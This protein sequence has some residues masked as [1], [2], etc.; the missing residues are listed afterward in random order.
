M[1]IVDR[2]QPAEVR[3]RDDIGSNPT[4]NRTMREII[5]ARYSRRDILALMASAGAL[6]AAAGTSE[7]AAAQ[8]SGNVDA[9]LNRGIPAPQIGTLTFPEIPHG[10]DA[11][12][13]LSKG[14]KAQV[15]LRWGDP[16]FPD[17]SPF[18]PDNQSAAVQ[19]MQ[20]GYN[21]DFIGFLPYSFGN[22][23]SLHGLL[24]V[25]HEYA[26]PE[27]MFSSMTNQT[28]FER[29]KAEQAAVEM[30]AVG[31]SIVEIEKDGGQWKVVLDGE[32]NR[33]I[34]AS[35]PIAI[36]GPAAGSPRLVTSADPTGRMVHGTF[37]NCGG[38]I[39]PWGT[40]LT[41]E[42]NF[43]FYFGGNLAASPEAAAYKR[44]GY[45]E[46]PLSAWMRFDARF[47]VAREPNESNRFGW[48]VEI[49]PYDPASTPVK[50]T[51]LGRFKHEAAP[52][53]ISADGRAVI[54]MGDDERFEYI[55]RFVSAGTYNPDDRAANFA[56]LDDGTLSVA[57]FE[58]N[59]TLAW[60]P[61]VYGNGPL[62]EANGFSSQADVLIE[63]R[64]AA[65]LVGA[66]PMDRPED[67][68]ASPT[69]GHVFAMMSNNWNRRRE[70]VDPANPRPENVTG[71]VIEMAPP[72]EPG[73]MDHAAALYGWGLFLVCG[74]PKTEATIYGA[75][76]SA[77]GWLAC[78]DNLAFDARGRL[79]IATDQGG[80]QKMLD[81]GDGIYAT[82][83][84]GPGRGV[85]RNFFRCPRGAE[86][87]GPCFTPDG[88][89]LFLSV[90]H[91]G[92]GSSRD[93]P[94]THWPDFKQGIPP[95]P[96]VIAITRDGGLEI[97]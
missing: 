79:W 91:P 60:L 88:R 97:G 85:T 35:T 49:D 87:A 16:L 53:V 11:D 52:V 13:R 40:I 44:Y 76:L 78:P 96:S 89:T 24:C 29:I 22:T 46:K 70:Q 27:L 37:G 5:D 2:F 32:Y 33:R 65:D 20:F 7:P 73:A 81:I 41:C 1:S 34:T 25:N 23:N 83:A 21:N 8:Q 59:G 93:R 30:A 86:A 45:D 67:V 17:S 19:A 72:G 39:T 12:A 95:R 48:V 6:L 75:G 80:Q 3:D 61:L 14:Y 47:D 51:A 42:E 94:S 77:N 54:Y 55:Y 82:D 9:F 4:D 15:L 26:S 71:H 62:T 31:H 38:G 43:T 18:N 56:L 63:A 69:T 36:S 64:R 74:N 58:P 50:R 66:T 68:E 10:L 90:Q 28:A 92:E 57:R 84:V